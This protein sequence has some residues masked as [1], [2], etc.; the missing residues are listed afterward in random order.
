MRRNLLEPIEVSTVHA[1]GPVSVSEAISFFELGFAEHGSG[2]ATLHGQ[3]FAFGPGDVLLFL[4]GQRRTVSLTGDPTV[5]FVRFQEFFFDRTTIQGYAL[6]FSQ[7]FQQLKGQFMRSRLRDYPVIGADQEHDGLANLFL[8]IVGECRSKKTYC[9]LVVQ[10]TLFSMLNI[11]ARS[12][13]E[14]T[15]H[16]TQHDQLSQQLLAYIH[17]NI[18]DA[19][20]LSVKQLSERFL[21]SPTYFSEFF[22]K[23][24]GVPFKQYIIHVKLKKA[25]AKLQYT[26]LTLSQIAD[27]LGFTDLHHLSKTFAKYRKVPLAICREKVK[28]ELALANP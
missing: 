19:K 27:D 17:T 22:K 14:P 4:P 6:N 20:K 13:G 2:T 23:R 10:N 9:D 3:Q 16:N 12:L 28:Q 26:D 8:L 25:E 21:V 24:F 5:H 18:G 1:A 11:L 7:W 15:Q